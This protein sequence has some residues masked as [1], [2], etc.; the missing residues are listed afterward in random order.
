MCWFLTEYDKVH[1][2]KLWKPNNPKIIKMFTSL[3][4]CYNI[5][6]TVLG[7]FYYVLFSKFSN[8]VAFLLCADFLTKYDKVHTKKWWKTYNPKSYQNVYFNENLLQYKC[9]ILCFQNFQIKSTQSRGFSIMCWFLTKYD[10]VHTKKWW[11]P[12]NPKSYQK[13]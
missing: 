13:V 1:T 12:H 5:V 7:F 8:K 11:K 10:K 2:K 3:K 9:K 6:N 4:I